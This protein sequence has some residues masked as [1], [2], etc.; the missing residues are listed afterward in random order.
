VF[1]LPLGEA[2]PS[3]FK[4]VAALAETFAVSHGFRHFVLTGRFK[5]LDQQFATASLSN[6]PDEYVTLYQSR[7]Y[8]VFDPV[9][10]RS[11]ISPAP[12]TF[13]Q[14]DESS[15]QARDVVAAA[16]KYGLDQGVAVPLHGAEGEGIALFLSGSFPPTGSELEKLYA[17][18][19]LFLRQLYPTLE[20]LLKPKVKIAKLTDRERQVLTLLAQGKILKQIADIVG[21]NERMLNYTLQ[22]AKKKLRASSRDQLVAIALISGQISWMVAQPDLDVEFLVGT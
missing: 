18:C 15:R 10:Q 7:G 3:T 4:E 2:E 6:Y 12:F 5:K 1:Q 20:R 16:A 9:L 13:D 22:A 14:A 17:E 11:R 21:V 8:G 19:W